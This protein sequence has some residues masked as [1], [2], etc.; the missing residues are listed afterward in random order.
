MKINGSVGERF[1]IYMKKK[2]LVRSEPT[3]DFFR[4]ANVVAISDWEHRSVTGLK[5]ERPRSRT[6]S[7]RGGPS[8][9][10]NDVKPF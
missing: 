10:G 2:N 5:I 8:M 9:A 1:L 6:A 7:E 3:R 4:D